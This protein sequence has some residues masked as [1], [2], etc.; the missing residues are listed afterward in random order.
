MPC[1]LRSI[2]QSYFSV[3]PALH[4]LISHSS[5]LSALHLLSFLSNSLNA[6][7]QLQADKVQIAAKGD[8]HQTRDGSV[9]LQDKLH[10]GAIACACV[11][12]KHLGHWLQR[13]QLIWHVVCGMWI[14]ECGMCHVG[15]VCC[16]PHSRTCCTRRRSCR[17]SRANS[18][19]SPM[20]MIIRNISV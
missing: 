18:S 8:E 6:L 14:V 5:L 15:H 13:R 2:A 9:H 7:E 4:F 12:P 19:L 11:C 3:T 16:D 10:N 20:P 1:L 17:V